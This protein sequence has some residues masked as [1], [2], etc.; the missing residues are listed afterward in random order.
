[1]VFL[2]PRANAEF[3]PKYHIALHDSHAALPLV[4]SKIRP[5]VVHPM[6]DQHF[7]YNAALPAS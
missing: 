7:H 5:I 4:T 6:L 2:G 1:M 3:I